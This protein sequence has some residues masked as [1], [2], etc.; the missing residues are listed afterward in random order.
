MT[1]LNRCYD[2]PVVFQH[3]VNYHGNT[4]EY[5]EIATFSDKQAGQE[6]TEQLS[7]GGVGCGLVTNFQPHLLQMSP[8][9][10]HVYHPAFEKVSGYGLI[11]SKLAF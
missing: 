9:N 5:E 4:I 1:S 7:Y 2:C 6:V 11:A 10:G 8:V 3:V